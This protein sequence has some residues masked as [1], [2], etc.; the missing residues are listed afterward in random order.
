MSPP[1]RPPPP[2][3]PAEP[4]PTRLIDL[5]PGLERDREALRAAFDEVLAS[6]S[7]VLGPHVERFERE[8]ASFCGVGHAVG[9]A[10]GSD[11]LELALRALGVGPGDAVVTSP[12]TFVATAEAIVHAGARPVFADVEPGA[13]LIDL[14]AVDGALSRLPRSPEGCRL[15][16]GG[17]RVRAIVPVHLFGAV[18]D[19]GGLAELA[20]RHGLWVVEDAAQALGGS[21]AGR[22][23]GAIGA[24]GCFSFFP[25]KTLG[26]LGDGGAV[27]TDDE[28]L[29]RELRSLRQ[30]GCV[31]RGRV[32]E[33][34]GRNSRL[35]ALQAAFLSAR[36]R[37]LP[38]AL[39]ER[40]ALRRRY[41]EAL[42]GLGPEIAPLGPAEPCAGHAAALMVVRARRR[43]A[44][45]RHLAA[46]G[47]GA[48]V[49]YERPLHAC[50]PYIDAPR[51]GPLAEAERAARESLALP[52]YPGLGPAAAARVAAEIE[53]FLRG[54]GP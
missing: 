9:V 22:A 42:A 46:R 19:A 28:R 6:G 21:S 1:P 3:A 50:A 35:D 39:E 33:R 40:R 10:S 4:A 23:A 41:H 38:G 16:P 15:L 29:A 2:G 36:L 13:W 53:A 54:G 30:H 43:D 12:F 8:L 11:A 49:Y 17:E 31:E 51:L 45:A 32:G 34:L 27:V 48:G 7:F 44:L 26:A 5:G 18:V 14:E 47:V 25:T 20:S 37:G 24:A 52:L